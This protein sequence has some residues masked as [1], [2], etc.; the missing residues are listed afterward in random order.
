MTFKFNSKKFL[1]YIEDLKELSDKYNISQNKLIGELDS[2]FE[3]FCTFKYDVDVEFRN[4]PKHASNQYECG[5]MY[6][7]DFEL[8]LV[9]DCC[10][11]GVYGTGKSIWLTNTDLGKNVKLLNNFLADIYIHDSGWKG[12]KEEKKNIETLIREGQLELAIELNKGL[13]KES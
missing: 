9:N 1:E 11:L 3:F 4:Y 7:G 13:N 6:L 2:V 8:S 12:T 5:I 10:V